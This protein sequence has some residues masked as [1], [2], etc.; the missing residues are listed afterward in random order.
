M[1]L[2]SQVTVSVTEGVLHSVEVIKS[3]ASDQ[4]NTVKG[5]P[6]ASPTPLAGAMT[7]SSW[8]SAVALDGGVEYTVTVKGLDPGGDPFIHITRFST[9]KPSR[10]LTMSIAPLPQDN[11]GVGHPV[12]LYLKSNLPKEKRVEFI[13]RLT[14]TSDPAQPGA[15]RWFEEDELHYRPQN[16]WTSGT[17]V[18]LEA[19]VAG[20]DAGSGAWFTEDREVSFTIGPARVSTVDVN[21]H[22]LTCTENGQ[23][24]KTIPVSTGKASSPTQG[25][26]HMVIGK[27]ATMVMDSSTVGIPR[28]SP[29]AYKLTA[30]WNTRLSNSGEFVH[31]APWSLDSHGRA[32]VSHGCVNASFDNA[33]WFY[34]FSSRGDLVNVIDS[35]KP[36]NLNDGFS[37]WNIEWAQWPN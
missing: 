26:W 30:K 17:K 11:V 16:P 33:K 37:D 8:T 7:G 27:A 3:A 21:A 35:P 34:E 29:G 20:F 10:V 9:L 23:V 4:A 13:R 2:N 25:G 1:A 12:V 31:A 22:T 19:K 6:S 36:L 24:I 32:N 15:W 28:G 18:K 5:S 14:V